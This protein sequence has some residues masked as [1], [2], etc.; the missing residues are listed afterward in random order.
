MW[1]LTHSRSVSI[2]VTSVC[3]A[4]G[5]SSASRKKIQLSLASE[6]GADDESTSR[7]T[8]GISRLFC[9]AAC[10]S[11]CKHMLEAIES[12]VI[13]KTKAVAWSIAATIS[14][15]HSAVGAMPSQSTH[16]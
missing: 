11:S 13:T 9:P 6:S 16:V 14:F 1:A 3:N 8:I 2:A 10:A 12:G 7:R 15:I 4:L 5:K